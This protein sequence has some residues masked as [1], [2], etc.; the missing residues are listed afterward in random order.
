MARIPTVRPSVRF[1]PPSA[2][3]RA[4]A[5]PA[6]TLIYW[7]AVAV[8]TAAGALFVAGVTLFAAHGPARTAK[9]DLLALAESPRIDLSA[10]PLPLDPPAVAASA[11]QPAEPVPVPPESRNVEVGRHNPPALALP[12]L[13][14]P[15]PPLDAPPPADAALIVQA[16]IAPPALVPLTAPAAPECQTFGTSV[17]FAAGP[18]AAAKQA[19]QRRQAAVFAARLRRL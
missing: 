1:R 18:A 3:P 8:A 2:P 4:L 14:A 16:P 10:S 5:R 17:A 19:A 11:V 13:D 7:P 9:P 15:P 12:T 6:T